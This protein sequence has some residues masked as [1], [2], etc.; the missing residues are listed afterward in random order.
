[1]FLPEQLCA[2]CSGASRSRAALLS[3]E[4]AC[5]GWLWLQTRSICGLS[6][7]AFNSKPLDLCNIVY[8]PHIHRLPDKNEP[9]CTC[10]APRLFATGLKY[11]QAGDTSMELD[12]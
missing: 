5:A 2:N 8:F 3:G 10:K 6:Q 1:M 12:H 7:L 11:E 4:A 9:H